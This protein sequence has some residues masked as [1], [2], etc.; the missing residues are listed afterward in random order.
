MLG[1]SCIRLAYR[2]QPAHSC[3][4]YHVYVY[5]IAHKTN[6]I[7]RGRVTRRA[8]EGGVIFAVSRVNLSRHR[9]R[10][11]RTAPRH[12]RTVEAPQ[13]RPLAAGGRHH[14]S[15]CLSLI[16]IGWR[17]YIGSHNFIARAAGKR[18]HDIV[19]NNR[20]IGGMPA[21]LISPSLGDCWWH[22][23][24]QLPR[25]AVGGGDAT[26]AQRL[27]RLVRTTRDAH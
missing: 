20:Y 23:A 13:R 21:T 11:G 19:S 2:R 7:T 17:V 9:H 16:S 15:L 10:R 12:N 14:S 27:S 25:C 1:K 6:S 5:R 22:I 8:N 26:L 24:L 4:R 18:R 3:G